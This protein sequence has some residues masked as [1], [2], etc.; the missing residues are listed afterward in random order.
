M[1]LAKI[2]SCKRFIADRAYD[3]NA[4][5]RKLRDNDIKPVI[6]AK[7]NRTVKVRNDKEVL[8]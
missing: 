5:R 1:L 7:K 2:G 3:A 4:L 6:P 8:K